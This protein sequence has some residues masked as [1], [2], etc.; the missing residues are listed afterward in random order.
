MH[1]SDRISSE[2]S[3]KFH[4]D[5]APNFWFPNV[6]IQP[7]WIDWVFWC[8]WEA[9][10]ILWSP[11]RYV[12]RFSIHLEPI[13]NNWFS[14]IGTII[15]AAT[16]WIY[17]NRFGPITKKFQILQELRYLPARFQG[18]CLIR[19]SLRE[20]PFWKKVPDCPIFSAGWYP[21]SFSNSFVARKIRVIT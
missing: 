11:K 1:N 15:L 8:F 10:T 18:I 2:K 9:K 4:L 20:I 13:F 5:L 21:I 19:N 12:G 17:S 14:T 16:G 6:W 3:S 7:G